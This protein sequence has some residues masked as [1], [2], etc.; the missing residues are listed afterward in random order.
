MKK[1][2]IIYSEHGLCLSFIETLLTENG[3]Q[4]QYELLKTRS[5]GE[6]ETLL[7]DNSKILLL[8][9]NSMNM[10]EALDLVEKV[11]S[12]NPDLKIIVISVK[13]EMKMIKRFFDRGVKGYL[14]KDTDY[15]EFLKALAQI[16]D[17]NVYISNDSKEALV[18]YICSIDD[19]KEKSGPRN[20]ELTVRELDVLNL[21]CDGFRT[22]DI[23]ER[24]FISTHTVESH[25][26]NILLK[27]NIN[28]SSQLVKYALENSLVN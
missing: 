28:S 24:L 16:I 15:K 4:Q 6:I 10:L 22:K 1:E 18:N 21:I 25:R 17:G 14:G 9:L 3:F 12:T 7:N 2:T 5:L 23:A 8:Y 20:A 27:F 26:R 13:S 11:L 19:E